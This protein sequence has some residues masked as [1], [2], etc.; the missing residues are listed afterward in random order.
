MLG[1]L[2]L[3]VVS[4]VYRASDK[5]AEQ[6]TDPQADHDLHVNDIPLNEIPGVEGPACHPLHFR[7]GL[8][9]AIMAALASLSAGTIESYLQF[10]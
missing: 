7:R 10:R 8:T 5:R 4:S 9:A 3:A 1:L 2:R 6:E